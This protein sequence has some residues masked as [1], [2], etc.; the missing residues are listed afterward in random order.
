MAAKDFAA[1]ADLRPS[2]VAHYNAAVCL[3]RLARLPE[4]D[5][6]AEHAMAL[7]AKAALVPLLRAQLAIAASQPA[8]AERH[9]AKALE[10]G[11]PEAPLR[12]LRGWS[13]LGSG[14]AAEALA[15]FEAA[16]AAPGA[17]AL[18]AFGRG[19]ALVETGALEAAYAAFETAAARDGT[20]TAAAKNRDALGVLF[21]KSR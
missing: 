7:D 6:A 14:R 21:P 19:L 9:F 10:L 5:A 17:P 11:A 15:D 1:S 18:V 2:A 3:A 20:L 16:D 4:A 8:V 13:R 12:G